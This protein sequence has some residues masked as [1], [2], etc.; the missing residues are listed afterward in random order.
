MGKTED[1]VGLTWTE[2][3]RIRSNFAHLSSFANSYVDG[4]L[5]SNS[6]RMRFLLQ[7]GLQVRLNIFVPKPHVTEHFEEEREHFE[8]SGPPMQVTGPPRPAAG[9]GIGILRGDRDSLIRKNKISN[10]SFFT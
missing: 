8:I 7:I 2:F 5:I 10:F 9:V 6:P 3:G 1:Y 4:D